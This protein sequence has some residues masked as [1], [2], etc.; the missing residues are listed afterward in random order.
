[1]D[2]EPGIPDPPMGA[3]KVMVDKWG[4]DILEQVSLWH[5]E[6]GFPLTGTLS[7]MLLDEIR[8]RLVEKEG[9]LGKKDQIDWVKFRKWEREADKRK[10]RE[11]PFR[12]KPCQNMVVQTEEGEKKGKD[13][14]VRRN[15]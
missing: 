7:V 12:G 3:L 4:R 1:M 2:K 11:D 14:T 5:R 10:K 9:K 13:E 6:G 15:R 8:Q